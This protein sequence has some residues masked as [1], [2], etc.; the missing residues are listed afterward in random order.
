MIASLVIVLW[1]AEW[2]GDVLGSILGKECRIST[3]A[4]KMCIYLHLLRQNMQSKCNDIQL[5]HISEQ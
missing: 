3:N 1:L 5:E 2:F 4:N